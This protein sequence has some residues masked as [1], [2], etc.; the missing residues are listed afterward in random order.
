MLQ[1]LRKKNIERQAIWDV[2]FALD[3]TYRGNELGGE[4]GE[5]QNEV[6]KLQRERLGLRG[7]RTTREKLLKEVG[8]VL[9]CLDLLAKD[10]NIGLEEAATY[11]FNQT[12]E[13]YGFEVKL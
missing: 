10:L 6:K 9:I 5:L 8:D 2:S 12:S 7:S 11:A 1:R 13:K 3:L 4:V